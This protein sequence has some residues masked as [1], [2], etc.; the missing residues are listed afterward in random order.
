MVL[1]EKQQL[2]HK[3]IAAFNKAFPHGNAR[4]AMPLN[5]RAVELAEK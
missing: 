5:D 4:P 2:T 3:E 1:K